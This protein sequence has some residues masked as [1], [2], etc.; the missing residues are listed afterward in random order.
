MFRIKQ[1]VYIWPSF[2]H[3][4]LFMQPRLIPII[5]FV[6]WSLLCSWW[7]V[8]GIKEQCAPE[9]PTREVVVAP[10]PEPLDTA[11]QSQA[12]QPAG[13]PSSATKP[14]AAKTLQPD[15]ESA[16]VVAV[17]DHFL[18]HFPYGSTRRID[19]E[20]IDAYLSQLASYLK[21]SGEKVTLIGYT[22]GIGDGASNKAMSLQR[23]RHI[24]ATL[25]KKGVPTQQVNTIGKGEKNPIAS[26]DNP[27]GRYRNRRVEVR[28]SK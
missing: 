7:Y 23:A 4:P 19:D 3:N 22:D 12:I 18:I 5:A 24:K 25:V 17:D 27:Q 15:I 21:A 28:L 1:V 10:I 9:A 13:D 14:G 2:S 26:N 8:C 20:A 11:G 16:Q 6:A